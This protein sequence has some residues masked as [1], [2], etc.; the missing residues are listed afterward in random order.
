LC[1]ALRG[2]PT[3]SPN[4]VRQR[5]ALGRSRVGA[6]HSLAK[7]E[8]Y[9][10]VGIPS[11]RLRAQSSTPASALMAGASIEPLRPL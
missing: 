9:P 7:G 11:F 6:W 1:V 4:R 5:Q 2:Q 8:S 3:L 10:E